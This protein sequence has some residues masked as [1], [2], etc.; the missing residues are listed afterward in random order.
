MSVISTTNPIPPQGNTPTEVPFGISGST[1]LT[2]VPANLTV[3]KKSMIN[4]GHGLLLAKFP[5][6]IVQ[7]PGSELWNWNAAY[8]LGETLALNKYFRSAVVN[9]YYPMV[10]WDLWPVW[11]SAQCRIDY[12][13][14]FLP[15][16]V[17]DARTSLDL[18]VNYNAASQPL[19]YNTDL[20]VNDSFHKM[21]D[22]QDDQFSFVPP[23]FYITDLVNTVAPRVGLLS[24][25]N[26]PTFLPQTKLKAV[27]RSPY[28]PNLT[29]YNDFEIL[30]FMKPIVRSTQTIVGRS[31]S[32]FKP[33]PFEIKLN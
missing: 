22:D 17:G 16:K 4:S 3:Q 7:T 23:L 8:P 13:L 26:P 12:E 19:V 27:M 20:L 2:Q 33:F 5:I 15:V 10:P 28:Q 14:S 9:E 31:L 24:A 21:L 11:F 32:D 29:Q 6:N 18:I 1:S 30:V 25:V